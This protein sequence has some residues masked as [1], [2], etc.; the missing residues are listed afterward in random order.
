M[1]EREW[2]ARA[3]RWSFWQHG[4]HEAVPSSWDAVAPDVRCGYL[5]RADAFLAQGE[6]PT[7]G[8]REEPLVELWYCYEDLK[9]GLES[10]LSVHDK[11]TILSQAPEQG[12]RIEG[13]AQ[14]PFKN[15]AIVFEAGEREYVKHLTRATLII[16]PEPA[17]QQE[18]RDD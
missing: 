7:E 10:L 12:E 16:H 9:K 8:E 2:L 5:E 6:R 4:D 18:E 15:N 11:L 3:L 1:N 14:R 17:A 13:W